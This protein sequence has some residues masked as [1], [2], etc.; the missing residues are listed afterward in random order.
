MAGEKFNEASN[1]IVE[2]YTAK[3]LADETILTSLGAFNFLIYL[4]EEPKEALA[5]LK[6]KLPRKKIFNGT[7]LKGVQTTMDKKMPLQNED[8]E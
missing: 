3:R 7:E 6:A 2:G 1:V 8:N 5:D 4:R